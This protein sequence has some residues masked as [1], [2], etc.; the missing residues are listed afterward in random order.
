MSNEAQEL[1]QL[2]DDVRRLTEA[3]EELSV[4][5]SL[6]HGQIEERDYKIRQ[7]KATLLDVEDLS[8]RALRMSNDEE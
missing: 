7:L 1:E 5:I 6:L 3:N 2:R 8:R 4:E